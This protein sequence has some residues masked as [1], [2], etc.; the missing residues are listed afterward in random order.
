MS[1]R[2][3]RSTG[4]G[5]NQ[6]I[7]RLCNSWETWSPREKADAIRDIEIGLH[8]YYVNVGGDEVDVH[9]VNMNGQKHLRTDPDGKG[10]NNLADLS[11]C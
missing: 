4:K 2:R 1:R 9:V 8:S 11:D 5:E 6:V 10:R 7:T 3:V